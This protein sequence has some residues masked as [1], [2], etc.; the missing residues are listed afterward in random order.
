MAKRKP[1][2]KTVE[3]DILTKSARRC[4]LC[5]GLEGDFEI[6]RGQ[7][8]HVDHDRSNNAEQNLAFLCFDHHDLYDTQTSQSKA[9]TA[10]EL[11]FYKEA[12]HADVQC[13]LPRKHRDQKARWREMGDDVET[14]IDM[15]GEARCPGCLLNG[16]DIERLVEKGVLRIEPFQASRVNV[17]SYSLSLGGEALIDGKL[18]D[19]HDKPF[20]LA[21]GSSAIIRTAELIGL[22]LAGLL[23]RVMAW[24][25]LIR[26]GL[27][28]G[29][30]PTIRPGFW[31]HL[32]LF[33]TSSAT[34]VVQLTPGMVIAEVEFVRFRLPAP[35]W[36][37]SRHMGS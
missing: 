33:L 22:P 12:L 37:T 29:T 18:I 21:P 19:A 34:H 3:R 4:C 32:T 23:A 2:P 20:L 10:E 1:I 11:R 7:I 24:G 26:L 28:L 9:F 13:L 8:A 6:K 25:G 35:G 30:G 17:A 31:G 27:I 36:P 14:I 16:E 5:Y 15:A